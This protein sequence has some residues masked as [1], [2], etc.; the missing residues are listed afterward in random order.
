MLGADRFQTA[1]RSA[2]NGFIGRGKWFR[3]NV[4]EEAGSRLGEQR[5]GG[6]TPRSGP[7]F[8]P[9]ARINGTEQSPRAINHLPERRSGKGWIAVRRPAL[10]GERESEQARAQEQEARRGYRQKSIRYEVMIAHSAPANLDTRPN[11]LK[12]SKRAH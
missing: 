8:G 1:F 4:A 5:L 6:Q 11:S 10:S 12:F 7:H 9:K 2:E 3:Q